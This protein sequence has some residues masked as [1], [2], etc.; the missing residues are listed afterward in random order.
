MSRVLNTVVELIRLEDKLE[1]LHMNFI[2][3]YLVKQSSY[4]VIQVCLLILYIYIYIYI[5]IYTWWPP[6]KYSS[7][8]QYNLKSK[9]TLTLKQKVFVFSSVKLKFWHITCAF[10]TVL[11]GI[12]A[13]KVDLTSLE[14]SKI[15][16]K[17]AY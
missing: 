8:F 13:F 14:M 12:T 17:M 1:L 9:R 10:N 5:Y 3:L 7:L 2:S 16:K 15:S 11:T 6:K 4:E